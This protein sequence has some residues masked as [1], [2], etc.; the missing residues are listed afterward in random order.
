M[1]LEG[2]ERNPIQE[3][4]LVVLGPTSE[5]YPVPI[6]CDLGWNYNWYVLRQTRQH[7]YR[8]LTIATSMHIR[9]VQDGT[10]S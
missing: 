8:P 2:S 6:L 10:G 9:H 3:L 1:K 4:I 7:R 5:L